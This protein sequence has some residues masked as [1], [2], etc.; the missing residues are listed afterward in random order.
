MLSGFEQNMSNEEITELCSKADIDGDGKIDFN[1]KK[2]A[3]H[4][5]RAVTF[6]Y[7]L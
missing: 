5:F 1:G 2:V 3:S 7:F 6:I 4:N